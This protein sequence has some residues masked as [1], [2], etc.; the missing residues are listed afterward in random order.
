MIL[1]GFTESC[2]KIFDK[3]LGKPKNLRKTE[4]NG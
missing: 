3:V 2:G 4:D 1:K